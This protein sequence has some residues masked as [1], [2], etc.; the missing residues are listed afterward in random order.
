M[1]K[2]KF[3][4]LL[5]YIVNS[6]AKLLGDFKS[7][8]Q[9]AAELL[10]QQLSVSSVV[11]S[12]LSADADTL[13]QITR[14]D[15][16]PHSPG[17]SSTR[18][19]P[20]SCPNFIRQLKDERHITAELCC[21][22]SRLV[23]LQPY[24][25][26]Q[27][28]LSVLEV[29]IRINGHLEGILSLECKEPTE[30]WSEVEVQLC[31]QVADQ[32]ALTLATQYGYD[33]DE[34]LKL[35]LSAAEQ[36]DQIM[37]VVN[38]ATD[39]IEYVNKAHFNLTKVPKDKVLG[40]KVQILD[41]FKQYPTLSD[42][43]LEKA[44]KGE[45]SD[46]EVYLVRD[47]G[48][49]YWMRFSVKRFI[50]ERGNHFALV[51]AENCTEEHYH[52]NELFRLAWRCGLTGLYNRTHFS[53]V[54]EGSH[55]GHLVM[56]DLQGF[57]RFNDTY[58]HANGDIILIEIARRIRHFAEINK[59]AEVARIGSDE[60]GILITSEHS[61]HWVLQ[62]TERL[63]HQLI[64]PVTI[65]IEQL[66]PRPAI[67]IVDLSSIE[68]KFSP[69][70]CADIAL[71]YAKNQQG[72][73]I[74][75]FNSALLNAFKEDTQIERDLGVAIKGRQFELYYQPLKDLGSQSYIGAE[76]LLRWHHPK[77]GVL[78]PGAFIDIAEQTGLINDIG[79]WVLEAACKQLNLWQRHQ[80]DISMHVNVSA[81][82]F[83]SSNLFEQVWEL[84][85]R[86][87]LKP[88]SLI[89]EITETELME[90]IRSATNL[91]HELAALGVGLAIDD[92]GTGYSSMRYLKQFPISKLKIDRSF[93]SD[94]SVS[95]ESREIVSAII[96]MASA[97]NISLT[98]EGVE[99]KEQEQFLA[100]HLCH[101]AQ[102][103]LYSP[104]LR[105]SE[106][107]QFLEKSSAVH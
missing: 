83:F 43:V 101:Q 23:E 27:G 20:S 95:H 60:F 54:L 99:T 32:L 105:V 62:V 94:L 4:Q 53:R 5:E 59:I 36:S 6:E 16:S 56:I 49:S 71:Q 38:L 64:A 37:M 57:K 100:K 88:N 31:S 98:A 35:F 81:R 72:N 40:R 69:L 12:A 103:F 97:L 77:K 42:E 73:A 104:A 82:Q 10:S 41:F 63:Y 24:Y 50:S 51:N 66:D 46:E 17:L 58:G 11:V 15:T 61:E 28:I 9:I 39:L 93:I 74:Q 68:Q 90:D 75:L 102:G 86:Y 18:P 85:T 48:S 45:A 70:T 44:R 33:K 8:A 47:D 29:A 19:T 13:T 26:Q 30:P 89:L 106:F 79:S 84:V 55:S 91:C 107:S 2:H 3:Q 78:Y 80:I 65:G 34:R 96:A 87:R 67:A 1:K 7:T 25:Q 52:Q 14:L 92:F 76:A 21:N 22:D